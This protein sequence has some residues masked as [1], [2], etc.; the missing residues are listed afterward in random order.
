[1][2]NDDD[3][4]TGREAFEIVLDNLISAEKRHAVA[5]SQRSDAVGRIHE[6]T[7]EVRSLE[8]QL[9][10]AK[11]DLRNEQKKVGA[12]ETLWHKAKALH[13]AIATLNLERANRQEAPVIAGDT[14]AEFAKLLADTDPIPF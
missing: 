3:G 10:G 1:M 2:A 11:E 4:I 9:R 6:I 14:M 7:S 5:E 8:T 12:L 13:A